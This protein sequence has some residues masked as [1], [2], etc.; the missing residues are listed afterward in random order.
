ME[1]GHY[2]QRHDSGG[3]VVYVETARLLR[4]IH[5]MVNFGHRRVMA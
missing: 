2:I 3:A 5:P 4:Y 1:E